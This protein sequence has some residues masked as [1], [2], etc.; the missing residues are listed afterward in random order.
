MNLNQPELIPLLTE[1]NKI[2]NKL[3]EQNRFLTIIDKDMTNIETW[4]EEADN[5]IDL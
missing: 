2:V 5:N 1:T 4:R 3:K